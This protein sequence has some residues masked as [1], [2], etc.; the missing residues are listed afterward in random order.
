MSYEKIENHKLS[1]LD[2]R[3]NS[4]RQGYRQNLAVLGYDT[5]EISCLFDS[6]FPLDSSINLV[7]VHV[8][9]LYADR[10]EFFRRVVISLLSGINLGRSDVSLDCLISSATILFP[11]TTSLIQSLLKKQNLFLL[12]VF[13]VLNVFISE[14]NKKCVL[15]I[16]DFLA[17]EQLSSDA[18]VQLAKFIMLQQNCMVIVAASCSKET[19]KILS[20]DLNLLFGNFE[21]ISID[22]NSFLGNY[23]HLNHC[24]SPINA[25]PIF[26]SF[27]VNILGSNVKS[28]RIVSEKIKFVYSHEQENETIITVLEHLLY[29]K[30]TYFFQCFCKQLDALKYTMKNYQSALKILSLLSEGYMRRKE[31]QTLNIFN[32]ND[33]VMKLAR[34]SELNYVVNYG[35][36]YKIQDPLF[37]FWLRNVFPCYFSLSISDS[38]KRKKIWF[39]KVTDEISF[40]KEDFLK[41]RTRKILELISS[42]KDDSVRI[43]KDRYRLPAVD[44]I[45]IISYPENR[46]HLLVGEGK[47]I[48]FVGIKES[49]VADTDVFDFLN[50]GSNVKGKGI[51]K[52]YISFDRFESTA[53]LIAKDNKIITWDVDE[54]NHL[55]KI[56]N[57]STILFTDA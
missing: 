7:C 16:E 30:D 21:K 57:K 19:E 1:V 44:N 45:K 35:D 4:F 42:F 34:L 32:P 20:T 49:A 27:F 50:R 37:A 52:I 24:L 14:S 8:T 51:N 54:I 36:V 46:F 43:G 41:E 17:L 12:D 47:E 2:K 3:I 31:L 48:I 25:S 18:F 9:A 55:L 13:E 53:K 22:E 11:A 15:V 23:F 40:F 5:E 28:Y 10:N 56:Y 29:K 39:K 26:I 6:Y 33:L 38:T